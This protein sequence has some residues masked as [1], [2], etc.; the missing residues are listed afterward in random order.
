MCDGYSTG[1]GWYSVYCTGVGLVFCA[2]VGFVY[3]VMNE[4]QCRGG[5][6]FF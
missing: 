6:V 5:L 3:F 4:V 1:V 2:G